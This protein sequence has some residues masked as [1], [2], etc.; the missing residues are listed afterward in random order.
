MDKPPKNPAYFPR[1]ARVKK[2]K[3]FWEHP[4]R[5][6][7]EPFSVSRSLVSFF[8]VGWIVDGETTGR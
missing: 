8:V 5:H 1:V 2:G 7:A 3:L 6:L 4:G